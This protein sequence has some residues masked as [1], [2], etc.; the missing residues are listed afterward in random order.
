V[1]NQ[2]DRGGLAG[3]GLAGHRSHRHAQPV[4]GAEA[5]GS[6]QDAVAGAFGPAPSDLQYQMDFLLYGAITGHHLAMFG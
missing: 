1:A 6:G 3:P 5:A 4:S 2:R